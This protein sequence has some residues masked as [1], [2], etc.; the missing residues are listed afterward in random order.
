MNITDEVFQNPTV[1]QVI[2]QIIFPNLFFLDSKIGDI[3]LLIMR[4]FPESKI[5]YKQKFIVVDSGDDNS[6]TQ[7]KQFDGSGKIWQFESPKGHRLN[8]LHNSLDIASEHHKTY[9]NEGHDKFRD[10]INFSVSSFLEVTKLP[11]I[12]RIG[13]RYI[14]ECPIPSLTNESFSEYYNS[15]FP[16]N[17]FSIPSTKASSFS[18]VTKTNNHNLMYAETIADTENKPK[19]ILDFDAF[20][21]NINSSNFLSISDELHDIIKNEY[22]KT[23]KTP[24]IEHMRKI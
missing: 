22:F 6:E 1:K 9:N 5:I 2:F 17:R 21:E 24:V 18:I 11:I 4:E 13:L 3:Q 14:D 15:T 7:K 8:I 23:I 20:S 10:L 16:L 19:L 12:N